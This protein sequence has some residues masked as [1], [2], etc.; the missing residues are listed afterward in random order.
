MVLR[1]ILDNFKLVNDE[2][3]R[4]KNIEGLKDAITAI[5]VSR[6][7]ISTYSIREK[8]NIY[9]RLRQLLLRRLDSQ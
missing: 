4:K 9:N 5:T 2:L 7:S 1:N 3:S 6:Y 8:L